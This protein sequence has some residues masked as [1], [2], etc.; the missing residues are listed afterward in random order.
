VYA[1]Q[2]TEVLLDAIARSDGTRES[3][4]RELFR[5]DVKRG[6]LGDFTFDENGDISESPITI[7]RA[8]RAGGGNT[9]LS[10]EGAQIVRIERPQASLVR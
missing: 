4:I 6:L 7:L 8:Q 3:V 2:A 9:I 10:F 5:T 1:A